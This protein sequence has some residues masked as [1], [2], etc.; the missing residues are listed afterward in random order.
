MIAYESKTHTVLGIGFSAVR[1][2]ERAE[3]DSFGLISLCSVGP[4][5][6]V[7]IRIKVLKLETGQV[8]DI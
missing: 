7:L 3:D 5:L 2:D 1:S 4:I 6:A 8:D